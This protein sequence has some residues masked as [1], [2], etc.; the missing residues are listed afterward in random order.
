VSQ[1]TFQRTTGRNDQ[2]TPASAIRLFLKNQTL[3]GPVWEP[4]AGRGRLAAELSRTYETHATRADFFQYRPDF[5]FNTIITNP[6]YN[7]ARQFVER[8]MSFEPAYVCMLLRLLFIEGLDKAHLFRGLSRVW[9]Y[10]PR[11]WMQDDSREWGGMICYAW[12]VWKKGST[13]DPTVGFLTREEK[14]HE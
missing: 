8:A 6:P 14:V 4:A 5:V 10:R 1:E 11:V 9:I 2:Q 3:M 13:G 12:F 7:Q